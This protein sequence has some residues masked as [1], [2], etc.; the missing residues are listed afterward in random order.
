MSA[1]IVFDRFFSLSTS[2]ALSCSLESD[3]QM[4]WTRA[5][6]YNV[7]MT[8]FSCSFAAL[9]DRHHNTHFSNVDGRC[10]KLLTT[11]GL[12]DVQRQMRQQKYVYKPFPLQPVFRVLLRFH[13]HLDCNYL[14]RFHLSAELVSF[15]KANGTVEIRECDKER[16]S[17]IN[18]I[19]LC[20]I[21]V[22]QWKT[23]VR[24]FCLDCACVYFPKM[25]LVGTW[26][27]LLMYATRRK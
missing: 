26:V 24:C 15:G 6:G 21:P 22:F 16:W 14:T 25:F 2:H 9:L 4:H 18:F 1:N 8:A 7:A 12:T 20:R 27:D 5:N 13:V 10:S 3:D 17:F 19:C 11:N 23:A